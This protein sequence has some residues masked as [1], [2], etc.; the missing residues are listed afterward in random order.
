MD[1]VIQFGTDL[2]KPSVLT[3]GSF[4]GVHLGHSAILDLVKKEAASKGLM[5]VVASFDPHPREVL[6][7]DCPDLL[8]P[9]KER[10]ELLS[11]HAIDTFV[12][13]PFTKQLAQ[14]KAEDFVREVL[15]GQ[16][17]AKTVVVG[18]DH[19]FGHQREGDT[20][21]LRA[22]GAELDFSVIECGKV[23]FKG[24]PVSSSAIRDHLLEGRVQQA[25]VLLGRHYSISGIVEHGDG[26]GKGIGIPTANIGSFLPNKLRPANGVY[27]VHVVMEG[28]EARYGGMMNIGT[29]PTFDGGN[30]I[31]LEVH[32]FD[33][34]QDLYEREVRVEFVE[35]I[36]D[37]RKFESVNALI[38]QLNADKGRCIELLRKV[39]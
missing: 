17:N 12:L 20:H 13:L 36:R 22:L 16:F 34:D 2:G 24:Q 7:G 31:H 1:S 35:R 32:L 15:V 9:G 6:F 10:T 25:S 37:E 3:M 27:A 5:S 39:T 21:L 30:H 19:R 18:Y 26:R 29:R 28:Q 8:S 14:K 4:D 33:F 11:T 38:Q 23:D